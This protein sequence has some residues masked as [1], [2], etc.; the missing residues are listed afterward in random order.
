[1]TSHTFTEAMSFFWHDI[2]FL[3]NLKVSFLQ[4]EQKQGIIGKL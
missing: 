3:T 2:P 1:M 4:K